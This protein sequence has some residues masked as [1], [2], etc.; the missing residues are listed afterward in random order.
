MY[1][2]RALSGPNR[3]TSY[4]LHEG[5]ELTIG[6][7]LGNQ[8]VL[9]SAKVSKNHCVISCSGTKVTVK[10]L[11]SSNG[12]F[13]NG[14]LVRE[15]ELK[16]GDRLGVGESMFQV[17][18]LN[19]PSAKRTPRLPDLGQSLLRI[20]H[21]ALPA[22]W[23]AEQRAGGG[24]DLFPPLA[25]G[26][27]GGSGGLGGRR[28]DLEALGQQPRD[29]LGRLM[30]FFETRV[31]QPFYQLNLGYEWNLILSGFFLLMVMVNLAVTIQPLLELNQMSLVREATHRAEFMAKEI[32]WR[33][34]SV[35]ANHAETKTEIG[36]A[37]S[38]WGVKV[39]LLV[40]L[41]SRILAPGS[42]LNQY[43]TAGFEA[44]TAVIGKARYQEGQETGFTRESDDLVVAV[45]PV[46]VMSIEAGKNVVAA[47]AIVSIDT[48]LS[49]LGWGEMGVIYSKSFL[50]TALLA[51]LLLLIVYRLTLKPYLVLNDD[52]DR[53][54]KGEINQVSHAYCVQE[55]DSLW[56]II[57]VALQR[58]SQLTAAAPA[59]A[60][61]AGV[62]AG[63]PGDA[64][65]ARAWVEDN[66]GPLTMVGAALQQQGVVVLDRD[67]K[68][69]YL[70]PVFEE[71]S[72]IHADAAQGSEL[73]E[74]ARDESLGSFF[75][76]LLERA[77]V[78]PG[79]GDVGAGVSEDYDFAGVGCKVYC[80]GFEA[81]K[82]QPQAYLLLIVRLET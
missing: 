17:S 16:S 36:L 29:T 2:L 41:D 74:V 53:A 80:G 68:I 82:G 39:A 35:L 5:V 6:R 61:G 59:G 65:N 10:D 34:A 8:V 3:G 52:M 63:F 77:A 62:G 79:F 78:V 46:K 56:E 11:D 37:E 22:N 19:P 66:L 57:N 47:M 23:H 73:S 76:D 24:L 15:G 7:Q 12:I 45:E 25:Q 75:S 42:Q 70:N 26:A 33:N 60:G 51:G 30:W 54:L 32:A 69:A 67:R 18:G 64:L 55:L 31:M 49:T 71:M 4:A 1:K 44:T 20:G 72:G 58:L 50:F 81:G 28:L 14:V 21:D 40:D 13:I 43:L 9:N 48:S 27:G 38:A